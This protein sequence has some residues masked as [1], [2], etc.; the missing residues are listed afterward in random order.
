MKETP[1]VSPRVKAYESTEHIPFWAGANVLTTAN[2]GVS[3]VALVT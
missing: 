3:D 1:E 2:P